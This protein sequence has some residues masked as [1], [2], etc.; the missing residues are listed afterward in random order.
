MI[1]DDDDMMMV[2]VSQLPVGIRG[3][4][5]HT[6]MTQSQRSSVLE[7]VSEGNVH[8]L[9]LSPEMLVGGGGSGGQSNLLGK[10]PPIAFA[11]IDEAHCVS[12]WSHHFRPSYLRVCKVLSFDISNWVV[13]TSVLL[14]YLLLACPFLGSVVLHIC[15]LL[16]GMVP[17]TRFISPT[18][19]RYTFVL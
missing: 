15:W 6:N 4:C 19:C 8:F 18:Y 1:T 14:L 16:Y 13:L 10:L 7:S 2:Q 11:C 9:L 3:A 12:E 5:I 17:S